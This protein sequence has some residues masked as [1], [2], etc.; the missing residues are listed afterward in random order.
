MSPAT[1]STTPRSAFARYPLKVSENRR[2]LVDQHDQPV[3][4]HGDSPWSLIVGPTPEEA[5]MYLTDRAAKGFNTL[6]VNLLEHKFTPNAPCNFRGDRTFT[7][8][9]DFTT[10]NEKYFEHAGWVIRRAGEMGIQI[11]LDVCFL[12]FD[13]GDQGWY[14]DVLA[15]GPRR[16]AEF[17]RYVAER[18]KDFDNILWV[19]GGDK[20][21]D[22]EREAMAAM[23]DAIRAVDARHL[24]TG[25]MV[26]G[27]SPLDPLRGFGG[28]PWI[29][30]NNVYYSEVVHSR[31]I[32]AYYRQPTI[33]FIL[34]ESTYEG[35]HN[36]SRVQIRRQA[37]WSL[38]RGA[39]GQLIGNRPIWLFDPGW[40]QALNSP[41]SVAMVYLKRLFE[42]RPW[43]EFVPDA[44]HKVV[45]AGLGEF[46]GM[47]YLAAALTADGSCLMAYMPSSRTIA[48]D[49]SR[50][51][52]DKADVWWFNPR[53][54]EV[55]AGKPITGRGEKW[56][57]PPD[58]PADHGDW[59]VVVDDAAKGRPAPDGM[60]LG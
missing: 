52:G 29:D 41:A 20:N 5:E 60:R 57:T 40:L 48:V 50:L 56:L 2:Y 34:I 27:T 47:D 14:V 30:L 58:S 8:P 38:L 1:I 32:H 54:G 17:G 21:L 10:P 9:E 43:W 16:C 7:T 59:V 4:V 37:Y 42:S 23:G 33:P 51:S 36:A 53:T 46:R 19:I 25:H 13:G 15:N 39:C 44:E 6:L 24:C 18:Y 22:K 28:A 12:G 31:C 35:E 3:L 49:T 11:L 45:T 55:E 26:Q